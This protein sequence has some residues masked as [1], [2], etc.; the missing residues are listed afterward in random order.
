MYG[1]Y[2]DD[3]CH[4]VLNIHVLH[5]ESIS[6]FNMMTEIA[7]K[8]SYLMMGIMT[9]PPS[10]NLYYEFAGIVNEEGTDMRLLI[11]SIEKQDGAYIEE[12]DLEIKIHD[13]LE[14]YMNALAIMLATHDK[15]QERKFLKNLGK[16]SFWGR[17]LV[18]DEIWELTKNPMSQ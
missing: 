5:L 2:I 8:M 9:F 4:M 13:A 10:V 1:Y 7:M 17:L 15:E 12:K 14:A 11:D 18:L 3:T 16:V 6:I